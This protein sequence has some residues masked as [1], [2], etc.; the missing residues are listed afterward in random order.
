M[1]DDCSAAEVVDR[2]CG[3]ARAENASAGARLDAIGELYARRLCA[4]AD[5]ELWAIDATSAVVAEV[6]SAL[7]IGTGLAAS[8]VFYAQAMRYRLPAVGALLRAGDIGYL[9]FQ[10]IVHRTDLITDPEALADVDAELALT[11]TG[12]PSLTRAK[13]NGR[14]DQVVAR[15]DPDAVRRRRQSHEDRRVSLTDGGDGITELFG[16]LFT[17]DAHR[18]DTRL[19]AIA[20]TVC[21]HD[22]RNRG[23]RRADALGALVAGSDRLAC[24]CARPDCPAGTAPPAAPVVI[25]VLAR[26]EGLDGS[27]ADPGVA[28]D[29]NALIPAELLAE[30]AATAALHP[31]A[32]PANAPEHRYRPSK[33]L[34]DF[35]RARHLTCRFPGCDVPAA[36][37]DLDHTTPYAEGGK[38]HASNLKA[39]C[40]RD[41]LLK[42]FWGWQDKQLPD[43]TLIWTA[44]TGHTYITTPGSALLFPH[45]CAPTGDLAPPPPRAADPCT[46]RTAMMPRHRH[47]RARN[48]ADYVAAE[49]RRNR[50]ARHTPSPTRHARTIPAA[51]GEPDGDP[52]PF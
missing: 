31:L 14:I 33:A 40:R 15:R 37:C 47:T 13:L 34:A 44:P 30:V 41:H 51:D 43:G 27:T 16:R 36:D 5:R 23:Q 12:W 10:A 7:A 25:H 50:T 49:R 6:A 46:D 20:G 42:T 52:P 38:T 18:L 24:R 48:R 21:D 11:I 29:S 2:L 17:L 3:A 19:D 9:L 45:L 8:Y 35:V 1:F 22:P 4:G 26:Q 39:M 32:I 28:L